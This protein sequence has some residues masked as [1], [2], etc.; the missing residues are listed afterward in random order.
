[1]TLLKPKSFKKTQ[2]KL[3]LSQGLLAEIENYCQFAG[4]DK[5]SDFFVQ[6]AEY[7]LENDKDWK[8]HLEKDI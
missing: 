5:P 2:L 7:I 4:I 1:M 6:A 8:K 3:G